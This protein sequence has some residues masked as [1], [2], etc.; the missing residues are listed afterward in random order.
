MLTRFPFLLSFLFLTSHM[1]LLFSLFPLGHYSMLPLL[2]IKTIGPPCDIDTEK[3]RKQSEK[4]G[5]SNY[6]DV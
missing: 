3:D 1:L 2:L 5:G 4:H 6:K